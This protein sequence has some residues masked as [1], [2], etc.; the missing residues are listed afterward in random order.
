MFL[1]VKFFFLVSKILSDVFG[2]FPAFLEHDRMVIGVALLVFHCSYL[3]CCCWSSRV[4][5]FMRIMSVIV[6]LVFF[7][8][9]STFYRQ[10]SCYSRSLD[11]C[12]VISIC[13]LSTW[14]G[15]LSYR[16]SLKL[17]KWNGLNLKWKD[18][19]LRER[20]SHT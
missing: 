20:E 6:L 10:R 16:G 3:R 8:S 13:F 2:K 7:R 15:I 9:M 4:G 1:K 17:I 19:S 11:L 5:H 14:E 12:W 18:K